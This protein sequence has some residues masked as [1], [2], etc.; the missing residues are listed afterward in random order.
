[1][2]LSG[3]DE[4]VDLNEGLCKFLTALG[5]AS[6][7]LS[8][9]CVAFLTYDAEVR[10]MTTSSYPQLLGNAYRFG[11]HKASWQSRM[12]RGLKPC[13]YAALFLDPRKHI[14]F[15]QCNLCA[16]QSQ[17]ILIG[18]EAGLDI[19]NTDALRTAIKFINRYA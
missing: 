19:G 2:I 8:D 15:V 9:T 16:V 14:R 3:A 12:E 11:V 5:G 13:H 1:M 10:A 6:S 18:S 17:E 4:F 7:T